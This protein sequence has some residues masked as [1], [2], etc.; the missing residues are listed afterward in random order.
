MLKMFNI[1]K[2]VAQTMSK[3][4]VNFKK[5]TPGIVLFSSIFYNSVPQSKN[6]ACALQINSSYYL[7]AERNPAEMSRRSILFHNY[8]QYLLYQTCVNTTI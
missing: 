7:F 3:L 4:A 1:A 8:R 5:M 6:A 2:I